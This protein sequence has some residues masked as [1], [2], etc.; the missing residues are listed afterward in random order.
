MERKERFDNGAVFQHE[1]HECHELQP[2]TATNDFTTKERME[3]KEGFD[4]GAV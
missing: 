3:H 4:N 1:L 2:F